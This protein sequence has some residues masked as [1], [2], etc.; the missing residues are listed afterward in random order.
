[1]TRL[2]RSDAQLDAEAAAPRD[3]RSLQAVLLRHRAMFRHDTFLPRVATEGAASPDEAD[4]DDDGVVHVGMTWTAAFERRILAPGRQYPWADAF[5]A[6]GQMCRGVHHAHQDRTEFRG[7][8]CRA[9]VSLVIIGDQPIGRAAQTLGIEPAR[10]GL[11]LRTA[12]LWM[13]AEQSRQHQRML[14][15]ERAVEGARLA[16]EDAG[17]VAI[18]VHHHVPLDGLHRSECQNAVCKRERAA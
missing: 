1:M 5:R 9:L 2:T 16:R 12:L 7:G 13:E 15:R 4:P 14:D 3:N 10:A 17:Y 18:P 6:L 11:T 8:L